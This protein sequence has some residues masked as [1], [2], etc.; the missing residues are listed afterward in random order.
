MTPFVNFVR[1]TGFNTSEAEVGAKVTY[2]LN[3]EWSLSAR[4]QY[5]IV[6]HDD[7]SVEYSI[8]AVYHF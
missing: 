5:E 8:G 3:S 2:R 1:A 7:D 6:S 4:A